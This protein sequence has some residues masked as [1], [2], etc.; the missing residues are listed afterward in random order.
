MDRFLRPVA[1]DDSIVESSSDDDSTIG[2]NIDLASIAGHAS[3][4]DSTVRPA[5]TG[6][7][8]DNDSSS[9][10]C[11]EDDWSLPDIDQES[12]REF[13]KDDNPPWVHSNDANSIS[14]IFSDDDAISDKMDVVLGD[15]SAAGSERQSGSR[16][17]TTL[18]SDNKDRAVANPRNGNA[19]LGDSNN[20]Y[21]PRRLLNENQTSDSDKNC[22]SVRSN[23]DNEPEVVK[24]ASSID[25]ED[26]ADIEHFI[27]SLRTEIVSS[28]LEMVSLCI[29][30]S[31]KVFGLTSSETK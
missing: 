9:R 5:S 21:T 15:K 2:P 26:D 17:S 3:K 7:S 12:T 29:F 30:Q 16:A 27:G 31:L 20:G 14:D 10:F 1:D 25:Y 8:S 6:A 22:H 28:H 24:K 13:S 18:V 19:G 23:K 11:S 4:V